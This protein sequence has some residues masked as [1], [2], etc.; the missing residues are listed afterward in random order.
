MLQLLLYFKYVVT[1]FHILMKTL[2]L[3]HILVDLLV[4]FWGYL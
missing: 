4:D 3:F 2:P 1:I